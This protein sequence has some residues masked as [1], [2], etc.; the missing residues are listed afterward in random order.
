MDRPPLNPALGDMEPA[1]FRAAAARLVDWIARYLEGGVEKYPL[2]ARV[3]PGEVSRTLPNVAPAAGRSMAEILDDFER[4]LLPAVTHWNHPG[5][6]AYF[7]STGSAPGVLAELLTAALNQQ[8]MLW[9]T[10]PAATE[11]EVVALGWLRELLG[12]PASF[13]GVILDGGSSANLH[14]LLAA[15]QAAVVD[16]R[17]RGLGR[18]PE[19]APLRVYCTEHVHSSVD[20]A[21]LVLGL[22]QQSLRRIAV[23][24]GSRMR[25]D[26]LAAALRE[27]EA[28][29]RLPVAVVAPV[30]TTST[31]A[32]DPVAEIA[33]VCTAHEVWLHVDAA[34]GGAAAMLP[35]QAWIF[36]GVG[37]ADSLVVNPH[38]WLFT[39]L[40]L[41]TLYL[42]RLDVLESA[43]ALTPHYLSNPEAGVAR[44]LMD[45]GIAL[46]RRF[47]ALKLW[48]VLSYFG[49]EGLRARL[50]EHLRLAALAAA[51]LGTD[52]RFELM[53]PPSLGLV[54]FRT[55]PRG[56]TAVELDAL[57]ATLL[58]RVN[59]SG[60]VYLSHTR[61]AGR[62]A[63]RLVV[64]H[65][66]TEERH[67]R[68]AIELL[69]AEVD[70]LTG[71]TAPS[72]S[73][74][75]EGRR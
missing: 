65:L 72:G 4:V 39:P 18:R 42:R 63:L 41:S 53:A 52:G 74:G 64:G 38:K 73:V 43:L 13:E 20:K 48:M 60:E 75:A 7:P 37:R 21:V 32:V 5:F 16:V 61:L 56:V 33:D 17:T 11:L 19:L 2:L 36:D 54:C 22:G 69:R 26:A 49:A 30:G 70:S 12:L 10:S 59:A 31:A 67:V 3:A 68:R 23:D 25:P 71:E 8:A 24:E 1:S 35:E 6:M 14:A 62:F 40:D 55:A 34:Y 44:N 51:E 46:G 29:G 15:R 47:R 57:N 9:R 27:D 28:A 50:R 45:T 58:K 66:R